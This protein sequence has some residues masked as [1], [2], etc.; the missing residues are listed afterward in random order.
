M[1]RALTYVRRVRE[2]YF[3]ELCHEGT[4]FFIVA[5]GKTKLVFRVVSRS[6]YVAINVYRKERLLSNPDVVHEKPGFQLI[7]ERVLTRTLVI[8][9]LSESVDVP[10]LGE[11]VRVVILGSDNFWYIAVVLSW[12][13]LPWGW[14]ASAVDRLA[15]Q[16][17]V[18]IQSPGKYSFVLRQ[19]DGVCTPSVCSGHFDVIIREERNF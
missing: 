17:V 8:V 7:G 3:C 2:V 12:V 11:D 19:C 14:I 16:L 18:Q 13:H 6:V 1:E 5:A 15:G 9:A 10:F 4:V